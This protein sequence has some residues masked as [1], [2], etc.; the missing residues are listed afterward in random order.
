MRRFTLPSRLTAG[1]LW[2]SCGWLCAEDGLLVLHV[3][4]PQEASLSGVQLSAKGQG[5]TSPP[6]GA[7]G[8]TQIRLGAETE[9]GDWVTLSV[10]RP[11]SLVFI[12]PWDAR[13][14]VPPFENEADN[15]VPLVLLERGKKQ[16]LQS[17]DVLKALAE[18]LVNAIP[19]RSQDEEV[20]EAEREKVRNEIASEFGL[21]AGDIDQALRA[22]GEK[23]Q[24]PYQKG[25]AALYE[26]NYARASSLL[27]ESLEAR[28]EQERRAVE[29][30]LDAARFLGRALYGQGKY[31]QA[32]EA[33]AEAVER[34]EDDATLL[35]EFAVALAQAARYDEAEPL[36]K[37]S[38][39][40]KEKALGPDHPSVAITVNN[41]AGLYRT[42]GRYEEAEPLF[43]RSLAISEKALGPDHPGGAATLNNLAELYRTQG[44]YEEAE[45]L[46]QRSLAIS[47]KAL[48]PDDHRVANT[49]NNLALLNKTLGRYDEA[50][51][52]YKRSLAVLEKAVGPNHPNVAFTL[53]NLANLYLTQ[54]RYEEA[55]P[56]YKR[57][58]A[59]SEKARGP[60]HPDVA[61]T[62]NNL[63]NLYNK[64]HRYDEAEPLY[65]RTL[66]ISEKTLGPN[67]PNVAFTLDNLAQLY[68]PQGRYDKAEPLYERSLAISE[69]ALGPDHTDVAITL[70]QS[71]QPL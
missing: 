36:Y 59:I 48:G 16:A 6:T 12:S 8:K 62:L 64:Q 60:D 38:L 31:G 27:A 19:L 28:K 55:E 7:D 51:P 4:D 14:M 20:S 63:A 3:S 32:A 42:Q 65:E 11:K 58:L 43:Q 17:D 24:D 66:A 47:E 52:L 15:F 13:A 34:R 18:R 50:E 26:E 33:F 56:L 35:N 44:R 41:L 46:Y 37:R 71:R 70:Q 67:H 21:E 57:S 39:V 2:L 29:R 5:T 10:V 40:I 22:W 23:A 61:I 49:L 25:L 69:K 53:D 1:L 68:S 54:R 45:P 30:V 9:P